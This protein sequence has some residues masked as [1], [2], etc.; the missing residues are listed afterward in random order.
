MCV[1][2]PSTDWC[3]LLQSY[4]LSESKCGSVI[5]SSILTGKDMAVI[6]SKLIIVT[7]FHEKVGIFQCLCLWHSAHWLLLV[8]AGYIFDAWNQGEQHVFSVGYSESEGPHTKPQ[9]NA[10]FLN[11]L[12]LSVQRKPTAVLGFSFSFPQCQVYRSFHFLG[13]KHGS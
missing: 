11:W 3:S 6:I 13:K 4:C 5:V 2:P 10:L 8:L 9:I 7:N 1:K 12:L